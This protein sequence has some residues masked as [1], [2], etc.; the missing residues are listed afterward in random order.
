MV[1]TSK[2]F[3]YK[4][5][6]IKPSLQKQKLII[7]ETGDEFE[8]TVKQLSWVKRNQ[9]VSQCLKVGGKGCGSPM[10]GNNRS[11]LSYN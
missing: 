2:A 8:V 3:D 11:F 9:L 10:G 7:E 4:R 1:E 5:Y 6:Q